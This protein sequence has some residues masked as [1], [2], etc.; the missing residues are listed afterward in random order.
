M[1]LLFLGLIIFAY[2]LVPSSY[3]VPLI[4]ERETGVRQL[5]LISGTRKIAYWLSSLAWDMMFAGIT[6]LVTVII[7]V[8]G[9]PSTFGSTFGITL[10]LFVVYMLDATLLSYLLSRIWEKHVKAQGKIEHK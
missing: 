9:S 4:K 8:I 5:L 2:S 3:C 1:E 6:S 10:A 7:F